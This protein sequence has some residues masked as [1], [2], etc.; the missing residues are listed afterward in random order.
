MSKRATKPCKD[1]TYWAL[2]FAPHFGKCKKFNLS[3]VSDET[4][5]RFELKPGTDIS[6]IFSMIYGEKNGK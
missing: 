3:K 4:C 6:D 1:C 2:V 5:P